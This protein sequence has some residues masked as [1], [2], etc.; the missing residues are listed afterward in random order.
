MRLKELTNSHRE[1][2]RTLTSRISNRLETDFT[3]VAGGTG[4]NVG[5]ELRERGHRIVMELPS[6]VLLTA[7]DNVT[8]R[9]QMRIRIK[10][11]RDRMLFRPGPIPLPK[12]LEPTPIPPAF[13]RGGPGGGG[14]AG[15][16]RR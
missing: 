15:R 11:G 3:E 4:P 7:H 8:V 12:R 13:S 5:I 16:P 10:A 9:E 1:L 14:G 6:T 2:L